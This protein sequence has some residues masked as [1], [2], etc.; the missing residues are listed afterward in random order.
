MTRAFSFAHLIVS[1]VVVGLGVGG[2]L[3]TVPVWQAEI[4]PAA[5]RGTHVTTSGIFASIGGL[6]ALALDLG[7][8]FAPGSVGWR[9]PMAFQ[10]LLSLMTMG[11]TWVLPESP[12]CLIMQNRVAEAREVFTA[13]E[14]VDTEHPKIEAEIQNVQSSLNQ[15]ENSSIES[16]I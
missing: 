9:F 16:G 8:S 7:M 12:R 4:S 3:S 15:K 13:L 6:F 5:K 10:A 2:L 14:A 11:F 1:R